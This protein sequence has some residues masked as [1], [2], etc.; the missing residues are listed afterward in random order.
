M[1]GQGRDIKLSVDRVESDRAFANKIWNATKYFHLQW[2]EE[3]SA[4]TMP[5]EGVTAWL[6]SREKNL[7]PINRWILGEVNATA[8]EVDRAL[9]AF[10]LNEAANRL[11]QFGWLEFCDWYIEFSKQNL[12]KGGELRIETLYTLRYVLEVF[13]KALHPIMPFVTE[14]LWQS[15]PGIAAHQFPLREKNGAP[16]VLTLMLQ[17][18]P[19]GEDFS[20]SEKSAAQ[21][22][23]QKRF[24]EAIRNFRGENQLSPKKEFAVRVKAKSGSEDFVEVI[25]SNDSDLKSM[26]RL[27]SID[28]LGALAAP[29]DT[30]A[31]IALSDF[32]VDLWIDLKGL[33][34]VEEERKRLEKEMAKA[35]SDLNHSRG[36]LAKPSFVEKAPPELIEKERASE[37]VALEKIESLKKAVER[38]Q[39]LK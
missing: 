11:Y 22:R 27:T 34:D 10:E 4:V 33:V 8:R 2:N 5:Q 17:E 7:H 13:L 20:L 12:R 21:V 39:A 26:T 36:K 6:K 16:P 31:L 14:E 19:K 25:R 29:G 37:R 30:D 38:L 35:E 23:I 1:A 3:G 32:S 15:L 24:I 18:F 28:V 9:E